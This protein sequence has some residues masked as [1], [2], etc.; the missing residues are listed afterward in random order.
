MIISF[1]ELEQLREGDEITI[2]FTSLW[3]NEFDKQG[4]DELA[5]GA[6]E[7]IVLP[8]GD[9]GDLRIS[10]NS[11]DDAEDPY[12]DLITAN[13][14]VACDGETCEIHDVDSAA[15]VIVMQSEDYI[16]EFSLSFS[17]AAQCVR[18]I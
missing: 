5:C 4:Y 13:G 1:E 14:P 17:T 3:Q 12:I 10:V 8:L 6:E 2:D 16:A 15:E 18:L 7:E 11:P 9:D